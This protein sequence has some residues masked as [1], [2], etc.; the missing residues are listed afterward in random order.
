MKLRSIQIAAA[1]AF[2]FLMMGNPSHGQESGANVD[3][4]SANYVGITNPYTRSIN[5][6]LGGTK[7]SIDHADMEEYECS[8]P[9]SFS[10]GT[11]LGS[12]NVALGVGY[13]IAWNS[14][15]RKFYLKRVR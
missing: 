13:E 3:S 4:I 9:C 8:D 14:N 11:N 7:Y 1:I 15:T 10:F 6:W 5:I 2:S 12:G